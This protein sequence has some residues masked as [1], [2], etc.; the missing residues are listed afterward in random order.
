MKVETDKMDS[1][2]L[3]SFFLSKIND[4][5]MNQTP[6]KITDNLSEEQQF[7]ANQLEL[8]KKM[9]TITLWTSF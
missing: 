3:P 4:Y 2:P 9:L 7:T 1:F 6:R 5:K 8:N